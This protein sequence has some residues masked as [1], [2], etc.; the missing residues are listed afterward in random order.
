MVGE[1]KSERR[2]Q[3]AESREKREESREQRAE[4]REQRKESGS[5]M[6]RGVPEMMPMEMENFRP[7]GKGGRMENALT[8]PSDE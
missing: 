8:V 4:S 7:G 6:T 2:E 1:R 5:P 3:R